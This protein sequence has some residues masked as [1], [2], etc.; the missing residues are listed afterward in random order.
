MNELFDQAR[1]HPT[2]EAY[3]DIYKK[4]AS[5]CYQRKGFYIVGA[6]MAMTIENELGR[7][8][9]IQTVTHGYEAFVDTYNIVADKDM[10]IRWRQEPQGK[11]AYSLFQPY[12]HKHSLHGAISINERTAFLP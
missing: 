11:D 8:A 1:N 5:L 9:L 7:A 4:I 2:G 3:D 12:L 6:S 10:K